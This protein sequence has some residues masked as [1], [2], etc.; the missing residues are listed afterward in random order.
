MSRR[1]NAIQRDVEAAIGAEPDLL[2]LRNNVGQAE[3]VNEK[4]ARIYRLPYGL[5]VGSPDLVGILAPHGRWFCLELKAPGEKPRKEQRE[6][7]AVWR[8]F[9]AFVETATS[10]DEARAA[11]ARAREEGKSA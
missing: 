10:V 1:E 2:L 7:H 9:G 4:T 8:R 11:L 3:H 6:C 5:G